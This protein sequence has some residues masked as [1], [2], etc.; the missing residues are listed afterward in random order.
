MRR[1]FDHDLGLAGNGQDGR[2][3]AAPSGMAL[4]GGWRR[5]NWRL[6]PSAVPLAFRAD[7]GFG[8]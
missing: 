1:A 8:S 5:W 2:G 6:E 4:G 3:C 7:R